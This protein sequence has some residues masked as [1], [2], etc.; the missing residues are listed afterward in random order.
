[1][2]NDILKTLAMRAK[3]RMI[4]KNLRKTYS[5]A[6]IKIIPHDDEKFNQKVRDLI[7]SGEEIHNPIKKLMDD[8]KFM[9]LDE[10]GRERYLFET[11]EKY[12]I[13]REK[14]LAEKGIC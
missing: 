12:N 7:E 6:D 5:N 1:M 10:R 9:K 11:I 14:L 8:S 3:N 2:K 13:V 4:N